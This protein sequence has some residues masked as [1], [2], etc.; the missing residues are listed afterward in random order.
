MPLLQRLRKRNAALAT[1]LIDTLNSH[2]MLATKEEVVDKKWRAVDHPF[3]LL[4]RKQQ[5]LPFPYRQIRL[6]R[7]QR[8]LLANVVG[9][10]A[11]RRVPLNS[12]TPIG[13]N[14]CCGGFPAGRTVR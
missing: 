11:Q 10:V 8:E 1:A 6:A 9:T 12:K 14:Q 7:M 4:A 13:R 5:H 2:G 3:D